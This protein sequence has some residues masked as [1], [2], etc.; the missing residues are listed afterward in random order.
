MVLGGQD[1][2]FQSKKIDATP[3]FTIMNQNVVT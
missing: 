1:V 3:T 2:C